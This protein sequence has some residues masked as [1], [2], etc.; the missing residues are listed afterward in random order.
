[1][2]LV[3]FIAL[4]ARFSRPLLFGLVTLLARLA[5]LIGSSTLRTDRII[6]SKKDPLS[7]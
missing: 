5:T 6:S 1:M 2:N 7:A 3:R 4:H